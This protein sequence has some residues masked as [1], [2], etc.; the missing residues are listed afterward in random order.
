MKPTPLEKFL[1]NHKSTCA[2]HVYSG[3]RHCSCGRD[4][5]EKEYREMLEKI[6]E[7]RTLMLQSVVYHLKQASK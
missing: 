2:K 7:A 3:D 5:A 6:A 1:Q 4:E